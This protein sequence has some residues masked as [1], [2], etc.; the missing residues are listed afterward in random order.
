MGRARGANVETKVKR[1][2]AQLPRRLVRQ[3]ANEVQET[4]PHLRF[5]LL[6]EPF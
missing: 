5:V 3:L 1:K 2:A 4:L 6:S